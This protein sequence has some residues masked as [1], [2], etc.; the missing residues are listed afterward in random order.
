MK[1]KVLQAF[2]D[3]FNTSRV[4]QPGE[5]LDFEAARANNIVKLGLGAFADVEEA[6][7][8]ETP[9]PRKPRK[10]KTEE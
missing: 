1:V 2:R 8:V 3:K 10:K 4:F 9:K 7:V 5:V 6:P